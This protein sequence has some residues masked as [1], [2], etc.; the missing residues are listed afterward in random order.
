MVTSGF[1]LEALTR[2]VVAVCFMRMIEKIISGLVVN[3]IVN[4]YFVYM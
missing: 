2:K 1:R 4:K 3:T